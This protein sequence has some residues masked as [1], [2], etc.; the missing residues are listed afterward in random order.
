MGGDECS[1]KRSITGVINELMTGCRPGKRAEV[2]KMYL[3]LHK[4]TVQK[5]TFS[6]GFT[7]NLFVHESLGGLGVKPVPGFDFSITLDQKR[8]AHRIW[9]DNPNL[10]FTSEVD[11]TDPGLVELDNSVRAPWL[12]P[13]RTAVWQFPGFG[14]GLLSDEHC[15]SGVVLTRHSRDGRVASLPKRK[16]KSHLEYYDVDSLASNWYEHVATNALADQLVRSQGTPDSL[17]ARAYAAIESNFLQR[18]IFVGEISDLDKAYTV[19]GNWNRSFGRLFGGA[20]ARPE[21]HHGGVQ[22]VSVGVPA[23]GIIILDVLR[24]KAGPF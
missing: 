15:I 20:L 6:R 2:L 16:V 8:V 11:E 18:Q 21:Y 3:S 22:G 23:A 1:E 19:Q 4:D 10:W 9:S 13:A 12:A 14:T 24:G 5:E 7:R 17:Q